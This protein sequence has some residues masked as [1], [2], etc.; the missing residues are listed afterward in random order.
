TGAK[1]SNS[2]ILNA[3]ERIFTSLAIFIFRLFSYGCLFDIST[4]EWCGTNHN[5]KPK[6]RGRIGFIIILYSMFTKFSFDP[7]GI[8]FRP[9]FCKPVRH[10]RKVDRHSRES[11]NPDLLKFMLFLDS[12]FRANNKIGDFKLKINDTGLCFWLQESV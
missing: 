1:T 2:K 4:P 6:L 12:R 5:A 7:N 10:S 8:Y 11:G 9:H 3:I